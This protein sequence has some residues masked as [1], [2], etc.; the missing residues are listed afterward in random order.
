[1]VGAWRKLVPYLLVPGIR[2]CL[3]EEQQ[4]EEEGGKDRKVTKLGSKHVLQ[5]AVAEQP[6]N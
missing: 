6:H 2:W 3:K 5:T 4:E 1:M